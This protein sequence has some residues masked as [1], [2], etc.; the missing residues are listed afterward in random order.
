MHDGDEVGTIEG[1]VTVN[2]ALVGAT[3]ALSICVA[4]FRSTC[5][6][7]A[8]AASASRKGCAPS[9]SR[10]VTWSCARPVRGLPNS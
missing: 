10:P 1:V 3:P 9:V 2:S 6:P 8:A 7:S 4:V 5:W